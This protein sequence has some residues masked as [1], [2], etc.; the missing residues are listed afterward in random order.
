MMRAASPPRMKTM[1]T[2]RG[3]RRCTTTRT[4]RTARSCPWACPEVGICFTIE[5]HQS[6][7]RDWWHVASSGLPQR[8]S[9]AVYAATTP[10]RG[11][12][13]GLGAEVHVARCMCLHVIWRRMQQCAPCTAGKLGKALDLEDD[14]DLSP[15]ESGDI[16]SAD[17]LLGDGGLDDLIGDGFSAGEDRRAPVAVW[18]VSEGRQACRWAGSSRSNAALEV[19]ANRISCNEEHMAGCSG[20]DNR[21]EPGDPGAQRQYA[22]AFEGDGWTAT[23]LEHCIDAAALCVTDALGILEDEP[24]T[25]GADS[26]AEVMAPPEP[27]A[28]LYPE[29]P[30]RSFTLGDLYQ[31]RT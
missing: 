3:P 6:T 4:R 23:P 19:E 10:F 29:P 16:R 31:A 11:H 18:R 26:E 9:P 21:S 13:Q 12:L 7:A 22:L 8:C 14:E 24:D 20:H 1:M 15:G 17:E 2:R 5:Y 27:Q 30:Q 28:P 25:S